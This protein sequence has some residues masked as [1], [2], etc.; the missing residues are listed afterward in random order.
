M[1]SLLLQAFRRISEKVSTIDQLSDRILLILSPG[2]YWC[3]WCD[4]HEHADQPMG[5]LG[6][7]GKSGNT[8]LELLTLNTDIIIFANGTDTP[9]QRAIVDKKL[10]NWD[11]WLDLHNITI[12]NRTV[13]SLDREANGANFDEDPSKATHPEYDSFQVNFEEGPPTIRSAFI[14]N[15]PSEQRSKLGEQTGVALYGGKLAADLTKGMISNVTG[16]YT[17]GQLWGRLNSTELTVSRSEIA[18]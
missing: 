6:P 3:P 8:P 2:I 17:V 4:G 9:E 10:P 5:I 15:F 16:I 11:K 12:D 1:F 18:I 14:T 7:L 13:S